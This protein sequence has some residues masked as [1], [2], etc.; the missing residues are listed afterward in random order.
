MQ[1]VVF[2]TILPTFYVVYHPTSHQRM[3]LARS[4]LRTACLCHLARVV[5]LPMLDS[6]AA[7]QNRKDMHLDQAF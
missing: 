3:L 4:Q 2:P 5:E 7:V 6:V 1:Y